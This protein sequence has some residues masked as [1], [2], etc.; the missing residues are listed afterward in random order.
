MGKEKMNETTLFGSSF[1]TSFRILLLLD[2]LNLALDEK[3]I[4]CIDFMAIYGADFGLLDENLHGNGLFRFSEFSA[5]SLMVAES[6]KQLVVKSFVKF[7]FTK[8]GYTYAI[9][10]AGKNIINRISDTYEKEYRIAVKEVQ[11]NFPTFNTAQMQQKIFN[12]TID[13]LEVCDE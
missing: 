13:S 2:E 12:T 1:E 3:Q 6:I 4:C 5:K 10:N 7:I 11:K 8:T 9:S